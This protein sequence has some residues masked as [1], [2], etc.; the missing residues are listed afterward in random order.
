V[1]ISKGK[2]LFWNMVQDE[3]I[4]GS[5]TAELAVAKIRIASCVADN[6]SNLQEIDRDK[7]AAADPLREAVR[8]IVPNMT[9]CVCHVL[10][11][12]VKDAAPLWAQAFTICKSLC[13]QKNVRVRERDTRSIWTLHGPCG[14]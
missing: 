7:V 12:A 11:L 2:A 6:A 4:G 1:I 14:P 5:F 3:A 13:E 8:A 10:Q 9:R